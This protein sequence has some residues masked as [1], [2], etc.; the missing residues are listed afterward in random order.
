MV[1][2]NGLRT[3]DRSSHHDCGSRSGVGAEGLRLAA[4]VES[5]L[6]RPTIN[7]PCSKIDSRLPEGVILLDVQLTGEKLLQLRQSSLDVR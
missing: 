5:W 4:E 7:P 6:A 2:Q 3:G 1:A